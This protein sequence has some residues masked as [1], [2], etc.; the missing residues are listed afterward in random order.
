MSASRKPT[1]CQLLHALKVGGAEL[2]AARL[3]RQMRDDYRFVFICLDE[4]GPLG[5]ELLADG[6]PVEVVNRRPGLDWRCPLRLASLLARSRVDLIHA[7]QYTPF[8]YGAASRLFYRRS[9]VLFTEHG[10][11][12]PDYPRRKR[13]IANR[14]L[15]ERRDRVVGVGEAVRQALIRFEGFPPRRVGVVYNGVPLDRFSGISS[16]RAAVR[17]ELLIDDDDFAIVMVARLDPIKDHAT[18][19]RAVREVAHHLP[20]VRLLVVGDGP[21]RPTL[22]ALIRELHLEEWVR[23]LGTRSDVP[24][25]LAAADVTLLT[26][27]S[28]GIPLTLIEAMAAELPVTAT[29]VGGVSEVVEVGTTGLLAAA[30][31]SSAIATH[32]LTLA[33]NPGLRRQMGEAGRRRAEA[34]FS[35][36]Q[37]LTAY[38]LL[39]REMLRVH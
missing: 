19:F 11:F 35:E 27:V 10:R 15:L 6:F 4:L 7:H 16:Q 1:V 22:E 39:Y 13:K 14:L 25:L 3:A 17:R 23:L 2:L 24:R 29:D 18:A 31:D 33:R 8:F 21:E 36:R 5:E 38:D 9:P 34:L 20:R 28:E 12:H 30:E 26:S 32:L 37:M